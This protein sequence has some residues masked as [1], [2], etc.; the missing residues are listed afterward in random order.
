MGL[1][2]NCVRLALASAVAAVFVG[3]VIYL[4]FR[5]G[6]LLLFDWL[7]SAGLEPTLGVA[8]AALAPWGSGLPEW[9]LFNLPDGLWAYGLAVLVFVLWRDGNRRERITWTAVLVATVL[10][11][12]LG[13]GVGVVPGT[14]DVR[15]LAFNAGGVLCAM[16]MVGM[17]EGFHEP[18]DETRRF[19]GR[20]RALR[21]PCP[22]DG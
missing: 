6:D 11:S 2:N 4:L 13:Q 17:T 8:R 5:D 14:F 19:G 20:D 18:Q 3:G 16:A 21:V 15:D 22:G 1:R 9:A 12:E 7:R 10:I